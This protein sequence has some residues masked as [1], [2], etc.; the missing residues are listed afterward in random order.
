MTVL[1]TGAGA[2]LVISRTVG[3]LGGTTVAAAMKP[4]QAGASEVVWNENIAEL[5]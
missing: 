4:S 2:K 1:R 5:A 3:N